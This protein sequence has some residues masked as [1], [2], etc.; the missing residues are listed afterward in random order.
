[1][2]TKTKIIV[3]KIKTIQICLDE[4]EDEDED[5]EAEEEVNEDELEYL[6]EFILC[7]D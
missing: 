1:M 4:N 7:D 6:E 3:Q 2:K 5:L